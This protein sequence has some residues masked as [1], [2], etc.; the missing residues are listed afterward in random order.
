MGTVEHGRRV[1]FP[2]IG[3]SI[4]ARTS[5]RLASNR[6]PRSVRPIDGIRRNKGSLRRDR[7]EE[8]LLVESN[9]VLTTAVRRAV[10]ARASNLKNG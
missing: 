2:G 4:L 3:L 8:A 6:S 1:T 5:I 10:I 7:M 9:A